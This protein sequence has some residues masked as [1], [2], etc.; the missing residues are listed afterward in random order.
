[1]SLIEEYRA[2]VQQGALEADDAQFTTL[3]QLSELSNRLRGWSPGLKSMLYGRSGPGVKGAYLFGGVGRGKSMIMDM[4]FDAAPVSRKRRAHFHEFMQ[5]VHA[6]IAEQ[7][8]SRSGDPIAK[9]AQTIASEAWLLCFDEVQVTDI[10]DAMILGR[11]FEALFGRGVVFVATSNRA[12]EDLYKNGVNRQLFAP[13]IDMIRAHTRV[14]EVNAA[15]DFRLERLEAAGLWHTPLGPSAREAMDQAWSRLICGDDERGEVLTVQGRSLRAPRTAAGAAR[16]TFDELCGQALGAAD[17]LALTR[18]Y[19][20][21]F[22]DGIPILTPARRNEAKRFVTLIDTLY[23]ARAKL[24]ASAD[25]DPDALY[26]QGDGAFEF[27]R[28]A[29]RLLEMRSHEYL[30]AERE[31]A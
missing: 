18:R 3:Q 29:S 8:R 14:I 7:R 19:H 20:T 16:F 13:F 24:V 1:M 21:L 4:F 30:A 5:E 2:R 23:E 9:V 28:T 17:Y 26:P 25:G 11:L 27:Q 22:I 6:G 10:G 31:A 12:P 15:R